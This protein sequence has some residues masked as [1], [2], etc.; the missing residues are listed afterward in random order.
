MGDTQRKELDV[1]VLHSSIDV[2]KCVQECLGRHST[3]GSET[4]SKD[5][6]SVG[7]DLRMRRVFFSSNIGE[8]SITIPNCFC[9]IDFC[10]SL[11]LHWDPN[12]Q[13]H[14]P[15]LHWCS[16]SQANQRKGRTGRT[17]DGKLIS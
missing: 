2:E 8:S 14:R 7:S 17:C 4:M 11:Q 10:R 9:V 5:C 3:A 15:R 13:R 6:S 12:L 16:K 1:A